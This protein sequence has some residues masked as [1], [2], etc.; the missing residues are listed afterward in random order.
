MVHVCG[1]AGVDGEPSELS[2]CFGWQRANN[3]RAFKKLPFECCAISLSPFEDPCCDPAGNCFEIMNIVP[4]L[5]KYHRNPVT[6]EKMSG[7]DIT[8]LHY[9]KNSE[10][11]YHC[12]STFAVFNENS[13]IVAIKTTGNVFSHEAIKELCIKNKNWKDL[14]DD[15]PFKREDLITLQVC[16]A[17]ASKRHAAP[18]PFSAHP[19]LLLHV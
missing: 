1:C 15:S 8:R 3:N 16:R 6:G 18:D 19:L 10:G 12:P 9:H 5:K 13:H 11:K 17:T 14:I 4:F 2:P 7:K